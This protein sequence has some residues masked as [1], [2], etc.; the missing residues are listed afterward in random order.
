MSAPPKEYD[1]AGV[2]GVVAALVILWWILKA[3]I[4]QAD[5]SK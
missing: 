1:G 5:N 3:I 4:S 2:M